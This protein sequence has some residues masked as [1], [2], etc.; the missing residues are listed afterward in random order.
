MGFISAPDR[1]KLHTRAKEQ[2][3]RKRI[4]P[5]IL[6]KMLILQQLF[7]L[8]DEELGFQAN[9]RLSFEEFFRVGVMNNLSDATTIA[10][11]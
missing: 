10:F 2:S 6:F 8:S 9:D 7:N 1:E 11:F 4:D 5:L 3:G